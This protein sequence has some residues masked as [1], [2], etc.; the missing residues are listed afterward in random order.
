MDRPFKEQPAA[1]RQRQAGGVE[2]NG[3]LAAR[4]PQVLVPEHQDQ[5]DVPTPDIDAQALEAA[6]KEQAGVEE[7]S[8]RSWM[9]PLCKIM[10]PLHLA[11][12]ALSLTRLQTLL[13]PLLNCSCPTC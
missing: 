10:S 12:S 5:D 13:E 2:P 7:V 9:H 1:K 4:A 8:S 6:E 3:A 11:P